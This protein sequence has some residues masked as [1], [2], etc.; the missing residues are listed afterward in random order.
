MFDIVPLPY[1]FTYRMPRSAPFFK[2]GQLSNPP[3][4]S[5]PNQVFQLLLPS[6]LTASHIEFNP[7]RSYRMQWNLNIQRQLTRT[8][9][10]TL[11]YV[12]S[13][14]VH[15]AHQMRMPIDEVPPSLVTF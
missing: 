14:G 13:S 12:G 9:A 5:F 10:L 8:M 7:R 15:L 11:G 2:G 4:S 3:P 1:L 6:S